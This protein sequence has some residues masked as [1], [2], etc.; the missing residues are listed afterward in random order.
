MC[1]VMNN[2]SQINKRPA[3]KEKNDPVGAFISRIQRC[4]EMAKAIAAHL[5]DHMGVDPDSVNWGHV[6]DAGH[7]EQA[8][9]DI[10]EAHKIATPSK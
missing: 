5:E 2:Q 7:I 10:C 1:D 4:N 6:G 3:R 8:L 9:R